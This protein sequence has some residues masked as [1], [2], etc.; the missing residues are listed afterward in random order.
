MFFRNEDRHNSRLA[1]Y[2]HIIARAP[3]PTSSNFQRARLAATPTETPLN[4]R[5]TSITQTVML[6]YGT[7]P[8]GWK[9][10]IS[11]YRA[12][13]IP[14]LKRISRS[15]TRFQSRLTIPTSCSLENYASLGFDPTRP[16][17]S[18]GHTLSAF[19]HYRS[20][21]NSLGI[22]STSEILQR[23]YAASNTEAK[24]TETTLDR[25]SPQFK[26]IAAIKQDYLCS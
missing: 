4:D 6:A 23:L 26:Y 20:Q 14:S 24:P 22:S 12:E 11:S 25:P 13:H 17:T 16:G 9:N 5:R 1:R 2:Y 7:I 21:L 18:W 19:T 15:T 8:F 10:A 3:P